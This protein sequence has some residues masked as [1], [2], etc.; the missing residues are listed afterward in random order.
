M[1]ASMKIPAIGAVVWMAVCMVGWS[2][3]AQQSAAGG[4]KPGAWQVH[5]VVTPSMGGPVTST[6]HVC[7][8]K[9]SDFWTRSRPGMSCDA[10]TIRVNGSVVHV[11]LSCKGSAGPVKWTAHTVVDEQ[12]NAAGSSFH[13]NGKTTTTTVMPGGNP[14][15]ATATMVADGTYDG[16][17]AAR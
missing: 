11:E 5:S 17:C 16:A 2:A 8:T 3:Q 14:M 12:F 7:A 15:T 6:V 4:L 1:L 9:A 13:A 10:P